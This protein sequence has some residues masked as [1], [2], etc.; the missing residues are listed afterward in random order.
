MQCID[1]ASPNGFVFFII[2]NNTILVLFLHAGFISHQSKDELDSSHLS[3][4]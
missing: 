2:E 3:L 1:S 4:K